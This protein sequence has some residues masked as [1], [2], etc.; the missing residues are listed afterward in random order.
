MK[1]YRSVEQPQVG[2]WADHKAGDLDP[3]RV[4]RVADDLY[5]DDTVIWLDILG[6]EVGPVPASNYTF[7]REE[8]R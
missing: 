5:E 8:G 2:D 3:R 1:A 4:S 6:K 7:T